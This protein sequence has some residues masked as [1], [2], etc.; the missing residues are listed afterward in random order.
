MRIILHQK[1]NIYMKMIYFNKSKNK[2]YPKFIQN[3]D[4]T[5][6]YFIDNNNKE[7]QFLEINEGKKIIILNAPLKFVKVLE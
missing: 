5:H 4:D 1:I 7:W 6:Y 3:K 2:K